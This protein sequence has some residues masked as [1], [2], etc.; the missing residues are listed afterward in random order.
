MESKPTAIVIY[1]EFELPKGKLDEFLEVSKVL[2]EG[3]KK[4]HG[5]IRYDLH[6]V[7][8]NPHKFVLFEEWESKEDL[9]VHL[10][11]ENVEKTIKPYF[12][13]FVEGSWKITSYEVKGPHKLSI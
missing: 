8:S 7:V 12:T 2:V 11:S 10:K 1:V 3:S 4:D 5:C 9:D 13:Q 6:N